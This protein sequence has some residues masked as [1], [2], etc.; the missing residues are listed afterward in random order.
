[1][2]ESRATRLVWG[3]SD[4][5]V[6]IRG[7]PPS[8][9]LAKPLQR[10]SLGCGRSH[11]YQDQVWLART[12]R[13]RTARNRLV[14]NRGEN[15]SSGEWDKS[16]VARILH[17]PRWDARRK[18]SNRGCSERAERA[19]ER[20]CCVAGIETGRL[21]GSQTSLFSS[22]QLLNALTA[23]TRS[24]PTVAWNAAE[25]S[26]KTHCK[27]CALSK[28]VNWVFPTGRTRSDHAAF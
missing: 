7:V 25:A 19:A 2:Y 23:E 15:P 8:L 12:L 24:V 3:V 11:G 1:M 18:P 28:R 10:S 20:C 27:A 14:E 21:G 4:N 22:L 17:E 9:A 5:S 16:E 26:S 13:D 6:S